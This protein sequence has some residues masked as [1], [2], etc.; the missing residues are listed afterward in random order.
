MEG[1]WQRGQAGGLAGRQAGPACS[2][3]RSLPP[4]PPPPARFRAW[5]LRQASPV[6]EPSAACSAWLSFKWQAASSRECRAGMA[7]RGASMLPPPCTCSRYS[8]CGGMECVGV[9]GD[10]WV[11]GWVEVIR[12]FG[13]EWG[14][15]QPNLKP[16]REL[17]SITA[18][19]SLAFLT[20]LNHTTR[21][22]RKA[23]NAGRLACKRGMA[24]RTP[25]MAASVT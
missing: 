13:K 17:L 25:A 10:G 8:S 3:L 20:F 14:L 9:S 21:A 18:G 5:I 4:A 7:A 24:N 2:S 1:M 22:S 11:L 6:A 19:W 23:C 16:T 12:R 15:R